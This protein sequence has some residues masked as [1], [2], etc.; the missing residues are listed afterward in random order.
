MIRFL[1]GCL[2]FSLYANF[3]DSDIEVDVRLLMDST[4]PLHDE[5]FLSQYKIIVFNKSIPFSDP[6]YKK[7]FDESIK[8]LGI[9]IVFDI[10]DYW[11]LSNAHPNYKMWKEQHAQETVENQLTEADAITTTTPF[12]ADKIRQFKIVKTIF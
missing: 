1:G 3:N 9:K 6:E 2:I 4:L 11:V 5:G 12:L 10:D 8:R 7:R